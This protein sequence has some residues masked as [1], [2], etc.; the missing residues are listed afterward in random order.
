MLC[1][2]RPAAAQD[3]FKTG[4]GLGVTKARLAVPDYGGALGV[5]AA[6]AK[7]ISRRAVG[8]PRV[9]RHPR[10]GQPE[11]LSARSVP[12]QPSELKAA[13]WSAAPANAYMVAFGSLD[14]DGSN[15]A[16]RISFRR[17]Q[18]RRR[19]SPCKKSIAG[20]PRTETRGSS[21]TS[22]P[23]TLSRVLSGGLPGIA[24]RRLRYVSARS[25]NKEIWVMDYDGANQHQIDAPEVTIALTPRWSPDATRIAFTCFAPYQRVISAQICLYSTES[26]RLIAFPRFHGTNSAPAWSPDGSKMA[27]MSSAIG[28]SRESW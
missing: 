16:C 11:L 7:N 6:S 14:A 8:G 4:T 15:L 24:R 27:F 9:F 13:D 2:A 20:R 18:S 22:L 5:R 26:D 25:G 28:R 21:R 3:W 1:C 17:A 19:R 12:G 23:T 10:I